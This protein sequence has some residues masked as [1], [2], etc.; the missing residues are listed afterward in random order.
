MTPIEPVLRSKRCSNP[1]ARKTDSTFLDPRAFWAYRE[2]VGKNRSE[3]A[4][5]P[6]PHKLYDRNHKC[7]GVLEVC[8]YF[9]G[10]RES[11]HP[12]WG[13]ESRIRRSI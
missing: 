9:Q 8:P 2:G 4:L 3:T 13:M 6:Y 11:R 7:L 12:E 5:T 10:V 1:D